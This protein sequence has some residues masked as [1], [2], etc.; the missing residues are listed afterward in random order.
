MR[1]GMV[2]GKDSFPLLSTYIVGFRWWDS[3]ADNIHHVW[4]PA[5][6]EQEQLPPPLVTSGL[7][8]LEAT[9]VSPPSQPPTETPMSS[10]TQTHMLRLVHVALWVHT[11]VHTLRACKPMRTDANTEATQARA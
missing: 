7:K 9:S 6:S 1:E 5:Q 11:R 3:A 8:A 10:Q 4:T 2:A